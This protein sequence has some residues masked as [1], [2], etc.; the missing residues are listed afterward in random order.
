MLL[1][2][3]YMGLSEDSAQSLDQASR[4]AFLYLTVSEAKSMLDRISGKT[5]CTSIHDQLPKVEKESSSEQV[6]EVLIAKSQSLQ[7]QDVAINP[8]PPIP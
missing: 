1:Q 2:H 5:S 6:E 7:S 8:E 4:G 3:F